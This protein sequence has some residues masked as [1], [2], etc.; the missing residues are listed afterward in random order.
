[1]RDW[2]GTQIDFGDKYIASIN[3]GGKSYRQTGKLFRRGRKDFPPNR[4][5]IPPRAERVSAFRQKTTFYHLILATELSS[6]EPYH[7]C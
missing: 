7:I 2:K 5:S 6:Y 1:M 4:N 3:L